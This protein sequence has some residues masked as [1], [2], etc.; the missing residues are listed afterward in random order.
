VDLSLSHV[1]IDLNAAHQ[2]H[3]GIRSH[4]DV[5]YE[6][7]MVYFCRLNMDESL[8]GTVVLVAQ[9]VAET[10][11]FLPRWRRSLPYPRKIWFT[12]LK[13]VLL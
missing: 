6:E 10:G 1:S 5:S 2:Q 7:E 9:V 12:L 11:R 4:G 3:S 8:H 13:I